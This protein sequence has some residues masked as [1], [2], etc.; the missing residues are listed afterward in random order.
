[1]LLAVN[2]DFSLIDADAIV[3][4]VVGYVIVFSALVLLFF[5][6]NNLPKLLKMKLTLKRKRKGEIDIPEVSVTGEVN[7]AI[8]I[9]L[10]MYFNELHD[11]ESNVITIKRSSKFYSP[12][13][14]KIYG[15]RNYQRR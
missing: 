9:A 14:S 12:W 3:I 4:C 10:H 5:V 8:G 7:A 13:S 6:F 2:F 11:D 15:L 1:M